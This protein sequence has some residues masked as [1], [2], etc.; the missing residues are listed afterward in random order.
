MELFELKKK[1]ILTLFYDFSSFL[2]HDEFLQGHEFPKASL[3]TSGGTSQAGETYKMTEPLLHQLPLGHRRPA[4]SAGARCS[5]RASLRASP[6]WPTPYLVKA[7]Y[8]TFIMFLLPVHGSVL[9]P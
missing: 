5:V 9:F 6:A 1:P 8:F 4:P 7:F 2:F 3:A